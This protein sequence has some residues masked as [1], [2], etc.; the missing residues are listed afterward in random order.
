MEDC[1]HRSPIVEKVL[2]DAHE[3]GL[4]F[5]AFVVDSLPEQHGKLML[6]QLVSDG[7]HC[8]YALINALAYVIR[9][10]SLT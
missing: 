8:S 10:V 5:R 9:E 7:I 4:E 2:R 3:E 6:K 1:V